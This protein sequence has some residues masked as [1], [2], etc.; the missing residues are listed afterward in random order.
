MKLLLCS[1]FSGVGYKFLNKFFNK[2]EGLK[3]L[4]VGYAQDDPYEYTS[5]TAQKF[6][7]MGI[8]VISLQEGYQ[9]N[10]EID[11]V[12]VRGGNTTRLIHYL[13]K[14]NQYNKIKNMIEK[15]N[16]LY[17]GS[18][19]GSV[20]VGSDTEYCLRSEPYDYDVKAEFGP[21][22]LKGFGWIDK[23]VFVHTTP[24][25]MCY[26]EEMKDENDF[27]ITPDTFCYPAHLEDI[28]IYD[29][30]DYIEI[31]NEQA[32]YVN[33]DEKYMLTDDWS[34]LDFRTVEELRQQD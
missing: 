26:T 18:S 30:D 33:G 19:A 25:R 4:F 1:D 14:Y 7:D 20:L 11:I 34:G 15:G 10:D 13:R 2:T 22:A 27:F 29:E 9:F 5:G 3:C 23:M 21:D 8:K 28:K 6:K 17:I 16:A 24:N 31:G 12:F 32:F